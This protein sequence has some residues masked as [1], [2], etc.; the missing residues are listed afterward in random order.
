MSLQVNR[1]YQV[2]YNF[3][4]TKVNTNNIYFSVRTLDRS[5]FITHRTANTLSNK[6]TSFV[7][8]RENM[9]HFTA[10]NKDTS[11]EMYA[12]HI[13]HPEFHILSP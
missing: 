11:L 5:M 13:I 1:N 9:P 12:P 6:Q 7:E 4:G 8:I 3:N 2:E 10:Y